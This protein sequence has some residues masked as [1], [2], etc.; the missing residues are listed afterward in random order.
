VTFLATAAT[1]T[2]M[3]R[4]RPA[5][6][7]CGHRGSALPDPAGWIHPLGAAAY[8]AAV[9]ELAGQLG[10]RLVTHL[11]IAVGSP[12]SIAGLIQGT[13]ASGLVC[14]VHGYTVLWPQAEAMTGLLEAPAVSTF[15]RCRPARI[16]NPSSAPDT[17]RR[18]RRAGKRRG[19]PSVTT[20]CCSTTS[21]PPKPWPGSSRESEEGTYT[22]RDRVVYFHT[23]WLAG[24][25]AAAA[26][27]AHRQRRDRPHGGSH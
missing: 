17:A 2:A 19:S 25:F 13:W 12:G 9:P 23:G 6:T 16:T 4:L 22:H 1:V 18:P 21:T 14:R 20:A 11:V 7:N 15:P 8:A 10:G 3:T 26:T 5:W 27:L 24:S